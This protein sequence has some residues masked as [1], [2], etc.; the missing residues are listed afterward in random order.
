[1]VL[2]SR[3]Q[4]LREHMV[5]YTATIS[6]YNNNSWVACAFWGSKKCFP[7]AS[8]LRLTPNLTTCHCHAKKY[9]SNF[10]H[11]HF[12]HGHLLD[13]TKPLQYTVRA[14]RYCTY[15]YV[16][17]QANSSLQSRAQ[18][19]P[20]LMTCDSSCFYCFTNFIGW[21]SVINQHNNIIHLPTCI[22]NIVA[23]TLP[24]HQ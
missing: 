24:D 9:Y 11:W 1:M 4:R 17:E 22:H 18:W 23:P 16:I 3:V 2:P 12:T 6:C 20:P 14:L 5:H 8:Y 10:L 13:T 19:S 7:S 15:N 21:I